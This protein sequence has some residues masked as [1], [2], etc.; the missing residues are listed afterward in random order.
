MEVGAVR[1]PS[2]ANA[3]WFEDRCTVDENLASVRAALRELGSTDVANVVTDCE[4]WRFWSLF[5]IKRTVLKTS[6]TVFK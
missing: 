1:H 5:I 3:T 4:S 6:C 2:I